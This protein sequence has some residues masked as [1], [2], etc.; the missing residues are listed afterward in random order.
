[1]LQQSEPEIIKHLEDRVDT[2]TEGGYTVLGPLYVLLEEF[3]K[4]GMPFG[5]YLPIMLEKLPEYSQHGVRT[6]FGSRAL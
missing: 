5:R 6:G 3:E 4:S 1:M 2:L